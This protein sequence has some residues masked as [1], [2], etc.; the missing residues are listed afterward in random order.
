MD[1]ATSK[2]NATPFSITDILNRKEIQNMSH[3]STSSVWERRGCADHLPLPSYIPTSPCLSASGFNFQ[4]FSPSTYYSS[5]QP[6]VSAHKEKTKSEESSSE[7]NTEECSELSKEQSKLTHDYIY[8]LQR[9]TFIDKH[10]N[11]HTTDR[12]LINT[13]PR[14]LTQTFCFLTQKFLKEKAETPLHRINNSRLNHGRRDQG[15]HSLI[16]KYSN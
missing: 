1:E 8:N 14:F 7:E 5:V 12:L 15:Q 6:I 2:P 3:N 11:N 10:E 4:T 9:L 13:I 16:N